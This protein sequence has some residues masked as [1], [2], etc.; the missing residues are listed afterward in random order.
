MVDPWPASPYTLLVARKARGPDCL[1]W[2]AYCVRRLSAI[3]VP[4]LKPD[5]DLSLDL[6]P[7]IDAIYTRSRYHRSINY[8]KPITPPLSTEET[9]WLAEQL[10]PRAGLA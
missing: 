10:K 9:S 8:T 5:P 6:Q 7:M 2:P 3:P 4:L 1:V